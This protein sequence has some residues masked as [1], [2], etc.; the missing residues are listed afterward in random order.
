[1]KL[2]GLTDDKAWSAYHLCN[3]LREEET[4]TASA[5]PFPDSLQLP[6]AYND[7]RQPKEAA[8]KLAQQ[9]TGNHQVE[10]V[11]VVVVQNSAG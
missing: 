1:M 8:Q 5:A 6:C 2:L 11:N 7:I 4:D 9:D 10:D 3:N